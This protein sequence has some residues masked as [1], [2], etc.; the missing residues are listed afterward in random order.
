MTDRSRI[1]KFMDFLAKLGIKSA[2]RNLPPYITGKHVQ[3]YLN[4]VKLQYAE[5]VDYVLDNSCGPI[6][7]RSDD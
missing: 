5:G 7:L 3:F 1:L 2:K 4:G 6:V